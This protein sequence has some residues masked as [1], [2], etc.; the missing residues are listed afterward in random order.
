MGDN[1]EVSPAKVAAEENDSLLA[2]TDI[3][4]IVKVEDEEILF[5]DGILQR[6]NDQGQTDAIQPPAG[7]CQ[8][9]ALVYSHYVQN[10]KQKGDDTDSFTPRVRS[11]KRSIIILLG[12]SS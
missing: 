12:K 8:P 1:N 3:S 10:Q 7:L 5:Q 11:D 6:S 9:C 2:D 4:A